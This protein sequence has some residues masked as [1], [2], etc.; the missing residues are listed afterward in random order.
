MDPLLTGLRAPPPLNPP[1]VPTLSGIVGDEGFRLFF[2]LAALHAALWPVVW[3]VVQGYGLL[4][5]TDLPAGVWHRVEMI[6][7]SFGAALIGFLLTAVPEWSDTERPRGRVLWLMALAWMVARGVGLVGSDLLLPLA[8]A[9]DLL[10]LAALPVWLMHL[11][12]RRRT[13]RL[14]AFTGWLLALLAA[15]VWARIGMISGDAG[16]AI[17][18]A[19]A[20][21]FVLLGVLALSLARIA[22]AVTNLVLD[23]TGE[24]SPYRPHPGR[25]NLSAGLVA[26]AL[27]GQ[28]AG[29]SEAV[30][31]WLWIAAGAAFLDRTA[32]GFIGRESVR[33]EIL[34]LSGAS[35]L[36]GAGLVWIGA[37]HLG[38]PLTEAGGAHLALMGGLGLGV[39]AVL[40]IA[41]RMHTGMGLGLP[42]A[43]RLAM[44]A[45]VV[46]CLVRVL[47]EAGILAPLA[48]WPGHAVASLLWAAAFLLW[49]SAAWPSIRDPRT[50]GAGRAC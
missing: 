28:L 12:W 5:A 17:A 6:W 34:A 30:G 26:L 3:V 18:G 46:A 39:L 44:V 43:M 36:A 22:V 9:S 11:S 37:A 33:A 2:P 13:T 15:A 49:L 19:Q 31:G 14:L 35:A 25:M 4:G 40:S 20:G 47:P 48:G 42:L 1:P 50:L 16:M 10:W 32:E 41:T 7:G 38:L 8:S 29:I 27:T 21:G 23:P 24:T 45:L